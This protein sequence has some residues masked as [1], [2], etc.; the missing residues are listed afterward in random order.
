MRKLLAIVLFVAASPAAA[1]STG[2]FIFQGGDFKAT[3][4]QPSGDVGRIDCDITNPNVVC[5]PLNRADC[6]GDADLRDIIIDLSSEGLTQ[7][8][9][10]GSSLVVW[11]ERDTTLGR[12]ELNLNS[13]S[14]LPTTKVQITTQPIDTLS[15]LFL[16]TG[17]LQ[18]PRDVDQNVQIR[19]R[20]LL[21]GASAYGTTVPDACTDT[22]VDFV[23]RICFGISPPTAT[24]HTVLATDLQAFVRFPVDTIPPDAT[25]TT[26]VDSLDKRITLTPTAGGTR[27]EGDVWIALY[28]N[29][30]AGSP[31]IDCT[32]LPADV[33]STTTNAVA[34]TTLTVKGDNGV[35]IEGC[36]GLEDKVGNIGS[37]AAFSGTPEDQCDFVE[38]YPGQLQTGYCGAGI[39]PW[40]SGLVVAG[41]LV[42]RLRR[43]S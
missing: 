7:N 8:I 22:G 16:K 32:Q 28:H 15:P 25:T 1:Q 39:G 27:S 43:K 18:F 19:V 13:G 12:C 31:G 37:L 41:A 11:L 20:D 23:Y 14:T 9:I 17:V 34:N 21:R 35:T 2:P 38:C 42:R 33:K 40:W 6:P 10:Y 26:G 24:N 3:W 29:A 36:I 5:K 30:P 4:L